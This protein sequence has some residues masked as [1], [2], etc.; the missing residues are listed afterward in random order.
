M[1]LFY[2]PNG[3]KNSKRAKNYYFLFLV[4]FWYFSGFILSRLRFFLG[5]F[6]LNQIK[7]WAESLGPPVS[8]PGWA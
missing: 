8:Q 3:S 4:Y 6:E 5:F 1:R 2:L 7:S